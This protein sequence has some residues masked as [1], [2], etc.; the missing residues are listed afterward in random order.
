MDEVF[1]N[2]LENQLNTRI[3][4]VSPLQGGDINQVYHLKTQLQNLVIKTNNA[5]KFP[6][7]FAAEEKGLKALAATHTLRIP[8]VILE[9]TYKEK[10]FL[11]LEYIQR[12]V[13]KKDFWPY[14]G[15]QLARL[16]I[17]TRS[18]FGF[19]TDNYIG[20][21]PQYNTHFENAGTFY[22]E[23]RLRPQFKTAFD[24]HFTF[25]HLEKLFRN[26][27]TIIPE[28]KPS[29]IH[30]DLWSGNYLVDKCGDPCLIDPAVAY[31]PREMDLAMM[32][33]FGG[34]QKELF[35]EYQEV[36]PLEKNWETRIDLWQL[37]YLLV[38][39]NL[40][41]SGYYEQ[42]KNIISKYR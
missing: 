1:K 15:Q 34:F 3:V 32:L 11:I 33:L 25:Q 26:I 22:V 30:G 9:G 41:G 17:H 40:F 21:L 42:V 36:Y 20:S 8:R 24:N 7:M 23:M 4:S 12:G 27:Q 38:H 13:P 14:F 19:D 35:N 28:E 2:F 37:Y 6:G 5:R 29:L 18:H 31:A 16:H 10:S 39:L